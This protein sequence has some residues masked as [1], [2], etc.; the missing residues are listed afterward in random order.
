VVSF[1]RQ[2]VAR[3]NYVLSLEFRPVATEPGDLADQSN[4][5]VEQ[6]PNLKVGQVGRGFYRDTL[7]CD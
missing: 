1:L 7:P 6:R 5:V 4:F 2:N 3:S